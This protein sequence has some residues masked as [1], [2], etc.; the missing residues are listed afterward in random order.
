M[1]GSLYSWDINGQILALG[2]E[3]ERGYH[4]RGAMGDH[5]VIDAGSVVTRDIPSDKIAYPPP[6]GR[7]MR[8]NE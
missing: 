8:E 7:A 3:R 1:S 5:V 2:E 4:T 6:A